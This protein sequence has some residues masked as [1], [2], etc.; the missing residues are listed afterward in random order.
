MAVTPEATRACPSAAAGRTPAWLRGLLVGATILAL[1]LPLLARRLPLV[2]NN[3]DVGHADSGAYAM[4][5][6]GLATGHGLK[7]PYISGFYL[8][9]PRD[10]SRTDDHWPP[11]LAFVLAPVFRLFG[12]DAAKAHA[13]MLAIGTVCLPLAAAWLAG[14]ATRRA[15][16]A[17]VGGI[18]PLLSVAILKD[19]V[20]ILSDMAL[21]ALVTAYAAA[22]LSARRH[23]AWFVVCGLLGGLAYYAKGSQIVLLPLLPAFAVFAHGWRVLTR[24]WLYAGCLAFTLVAAPWW[25]SNAVAYGNPFHSTQNYVSS[26]FGLN[27]RVW[28]DWD[29]EFYRV[30]WGH[31]LPTPLDRFR[32]GPLFLDSVRRNTSEYLR[33]L[34][35]GPDASPRDWP[36]LGGVG[37]QIETALRTTAAK[38][39]A[40]RRLARSRHSA[41]RPAEPWLRPP[42]HWPYWYAT[43][44]QGA[45]LLL[46]SVALVLWMPLSLMGVRR[47][48]RRRRADPSADP[49]APHPAW[50]NMGASAFL[51]A[52]ILIEAAFVIVFWRAMP[53]FTTVVLPAAA[54]LGLLLA[55]LLADGVGAAWRAF[56]ERIGSR[57]ALRWA[58][59][60]HIRAWQESRRG[61]YAYLL[62]H[63]LATALVCGVVVLVWYTHVDGLATMQSKRAGLRESTEPRFPRY[64][65]LGQVIRERLPGNAVLMSRNP[66][67][68]LF[69]CPPGLRAVGLPYAS[70]GV[71]FAVARYYGVTHFVWDCDRPGLREFMQAGHPALKLVI[72]APLPVYALD[73]TAFAPGA[74]V[75][76]AK[77]GL[78]AP[79]TK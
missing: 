5:G 61:R 21:A 74:L 32:D 46:G 12:P 3:G 58:W 60:A 14:A 41:S 7:V 65:A 24:R 18:L 35:L 68:L 10:F 25:I 53:R 71:I 73:Y 8:P 42:R 63:G 56:A 16:A 66:W 47:W 20:G 2:A 55:A 27:E 9:Y 54:T 23:G 48:R 4:Q 40:A 22:L 51:M 70:P 29:E 33:A 50:E 15:W 1:A 52:L 37:T 17:L 67:E 19:S 6:L 26:F 75:D 30:Y 49:P 31:N 34:I 57:L 44:P 39:H 76:P 78:L 64:H 72:E 13:A 36:A 43:L 62:A 45:G 79:V 28:D 59:V 69:Y 38:E 11:F 77:F